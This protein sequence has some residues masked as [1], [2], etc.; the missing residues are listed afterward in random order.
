MNARRKKDLGSA[1]FGKSRQKVLSLLFAHPDRAFY[2]R[3]I[4]AATGAGTGQ[5]QRELDNL[6]GAGLVLREKRAH[7][8]YFR[9][10]SD[11]PI[12]E[13]LKAIVVKTFGL[14][15]VL[16]LFSPLSPIGSAWRSS[17]VRSRAA[18]T[19]RAAISTS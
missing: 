18:K 19:L 10:N 6:T 1:L 15:D 11:A 16:R 3:E 12:F 17:T 13:E 7:Q 14:T 5:V 9:A 4:I 2:L 8:V